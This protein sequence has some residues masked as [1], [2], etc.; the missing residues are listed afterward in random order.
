[1]S[2]YKKNKQKKLDFIKKET[3]ISFNDIIY[4]TGLMD[5]ISEN[6]IADFKLPFSIAPFLQLNNK[7]YHVP[8]V[9]EES[10][11][12]AACSKAFKFWRER[13]GFTTL[14][15]KTIKR[16]TVYFKGD[17]DLSQIEDI[18]KKKNVQKINQGMK[19]RGGGIQG[20]KL[21]TVEAFN[22]L[23]ISFDTKDA[24]GANYINTILEAVAE[25]LKKLNCNILMAILTNNYEENYVTVGV[26]C[27]IQDL[28]YDKNLKARD[29]ANRFVDAVNIAK[30]DVD[31]AITHNKGIMNGVD[32]VLMATGN[33][34]RAVEASCHALARRSDGQYISMTDAYIQDDKF[35]FEIT[36]PLAVGIVGGNTKI[37]PLAKKAIESLKL[38]SVEDFMSIIASVG[39]AQ[40]FGAISALIGKGIQWG[41]M[42]LHL[43]NI[44]DEFNLSEDEILIVKEEFKNKKVSKVEVEKFINLKVLK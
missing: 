27:L 41:H 31:R 6:V 19:S 38:E 2:F 14:E 11:I 35:Y 40:N 4:E 1:M 24:M 43:D 28:N 32:S 16:G 42:R 5:K 44:L 39:L 25:E 29:F 18:I 17:V 3:G 9:T 37:H 36:L 22:K 7:I 21:E 10:S 34:Y 15:I 20:Y 33:D 12:V 30:I 13:G 8:M 23:N 26:S